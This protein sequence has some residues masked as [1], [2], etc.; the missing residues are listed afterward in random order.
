MCVKE[1]E[2]NI[3]LSRS[4]DQNITLNGPVLE[5]EICVHAR[6]LNDYKYE[7]K[8]PIHTTHA[9]NHRDG[10]QVANKNTGR[11]AFNSLPPS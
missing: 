4:R 8:K 10:G 11:M 2:A 7:S 9:L 1:N 5:P 6:G 3:I